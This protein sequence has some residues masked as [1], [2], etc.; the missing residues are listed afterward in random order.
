MVYFYKVKNSSYKRILY[1]IGLV[2][3]IT[4]AIQ[5]YW[6]YRNYQAGKQQLV[7][8]VQ[9]SLDN[10]LEE[11]YATTAQK[12]TQVFIQ[13]LADSLKP[14]T[15]NN[16]S[17]GNNPGRPRERRTAR[18][19]TNEQ[20][21]PV[22]L[23]SPGIE[24]IESI[25]IIKGE[26][27][28]GSVESKVGRIILS[29][30]R[31]S[32]Q[33]KKID[34]LIQQEFRRKGIEVAY[35]LHYTDPTTG[36]EQKLNQPILETAS[37]STTS[38]STW[39]P[40]RSILALSFTNETTTILKRTMAGILLSGLLLAAVIGCLLFLLK[41][42][43]NQ[44]QLADIKNDFIS[45]LTHEFKTPIATIRVAMEGI[46]HF[47][48]NNDLQKTEKYVKTSF[49]QVEK[50]DGMVE[51]LLEVATLNSNR[52]QLEKEETN[53]VALAEGQVQKYSQLNSGKKFEFK[54]NREEITVQADPFLLENVLNNLLD[55][56]LKYGGKDVHLNLTALKNTVE[57]LCSDSGISLTRSQAEQVFEKFYRVPKGN[58]HDVKGFGIGLYYARQIVERHGGTIKAEIR[59]NTRFIIHLPYE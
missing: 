37:I 56:A 45:N 23:G 34:S 58:T 26:E 47:N 22:E 39:L 6:N 32:L 19:K 18:N 31:D 44:K 21:K 3:I 5:V 28:P 52:L 38:R 1:F 13:D 50:L 20:L 30:R 46:L 42:I 48:T 57:I 49:S 24:N 51:K 59:R 36:I 25:H 33:L 11:Y 27:A 17:T 29:L 43:N 35:G 2:V 4:L 16:T 10:A 54:S 7:N 9:I 41:V 40:P 14:Q 15:F 8:E 53:I 12:K 55:N